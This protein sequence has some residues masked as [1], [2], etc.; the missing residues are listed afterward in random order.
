QVITEI[1]DYFEKVIGYEVPPQQP[2]V[3]RDFNVTRAGIHADGL[4][5]DE[6]IYN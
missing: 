3:G 2:F 1:A 6:E 4:L 5:K